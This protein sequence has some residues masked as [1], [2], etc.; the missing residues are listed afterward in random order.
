[1]AFHGL[2][3]GMFA[4][5]LLV[6]YWKVIKTLGEPSWRKF[7]GRHIPIESVTAGLS[8]CVLSL[9]VVWA[10]RSAF[11]TGSCCHQ[12]LP[13][14]GLGTDR[15]KDSRQKV[16]N[17]KTKRKHSCFRFFSLGHPVIAMRVRHKTHATFL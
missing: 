5:Q 7:V 16:L 3:H 9:C 4:L 15:A 10:M 1:M 17:P 8:P 13:H 14:H 2:M 12:V 6:L 11:P